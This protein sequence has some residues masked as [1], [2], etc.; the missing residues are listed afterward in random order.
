MKCPLIH[1]KLTVT[2]TS[3]EGQPQECLKEEC[4]WW[5]PQVATCSMHIMADLLGNITV[6][7]RDIAR[8][9]PHLEQF[10][11]A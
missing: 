11:R 6:H 8:K 7:L 2:E 3:Y 10:K 4:A 1:I 9:M 5:I